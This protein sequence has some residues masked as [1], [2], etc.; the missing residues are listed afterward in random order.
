MVTVC[1]WPSESEMFIEIVES[2][3]VPVLVLAL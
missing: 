2:G 3:L 1:S